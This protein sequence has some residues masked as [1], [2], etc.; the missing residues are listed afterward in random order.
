[1]EFDEHTPNYTASMDSRIYRQQRG[2]FHFSV[3]KPY[4]PNDD[5][6]FPGRAHAKPA[7]ILIDDEKEWEVEAILDF[8]E[9]HG[10]GQFLVK[11]KV[12]PTSVNSWEPVEGLENA[13]DLVQAWWADNMPG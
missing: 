1:M 5:E 12:Y 4:H 9:R 8:R 7:P 11:W 6:Q 3:V 2:V 13:E 10:R